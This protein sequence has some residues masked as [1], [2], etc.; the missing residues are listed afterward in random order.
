[1]G[2]QINIDNG[3][4]LTDICII[5]DRNRLDYALGELDHVIDRYIF[6]FFRLCIF[7]IALNVDLLFTDFYVN[8]FARRTTTGFDGSGGFALQSNF[9]GL[10]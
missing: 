10:E 5:D 3:G 4:T 8:G 7:I 2:L 9:L 1:M 6:M